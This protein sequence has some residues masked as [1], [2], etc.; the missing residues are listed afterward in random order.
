MVSLYGRT[1]MGS[2]RSS[3]PTALS[4]SHRLRKANAGYTQSDIRR[5]ARAAQIL[6]TSN[7]NNLGTPPALTRSAFTS[8]CTARPSSKQLAWSSSSGI[9]IA[10]GVALSLPLFFLSLATFA[11]RLLRKSNTHFEVTR[12]HSRRY[13][14]Q[15][16]FPAL[17]DIRVSFARRVSGQ[18]EHGMAF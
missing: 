16:R 4:D 5:G 15:S 18:T 3:A 17:F 12:L 2:R 14:P 9:C 13:A 7:W 11:L 10:P 8:G 6:S 1:D